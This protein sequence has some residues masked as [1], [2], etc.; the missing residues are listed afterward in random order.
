MSF[1]SRLVELVTGISR[2]SPVNEALEAAETDERLAAAALLVHVARAD[3]N[4]AEA[5][6]DRLLHLLRSR[7]GVTPEQCERFF[8][9]AD[10]I[11][12]AIDD[13]AS[14]VEMMGH[15]VEPAER[16]RLLGMAY[17]IASADGLL[18]EFEDDLIWR[19]GRLFGF[20]DAEIALIRSE[21][22]P[23]G[24]VSR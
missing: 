16:R 10:E 12:L 21:A 2:S 22:V 11:D 20:D 6:R 19:I 5:E 24:V 3:G 18:H 4:L 23:P 1:A 7:F 17:A 13:V 8:E 15:D 9:R 14:L